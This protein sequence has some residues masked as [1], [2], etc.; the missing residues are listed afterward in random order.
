MRAGDGHLEGFACASKTTCDWQALLRLGFESP[1][2]SGAGPPLAAALNRR[3]TTRTVASTCDRVLGLV[4]SLIVGAEAQMTVVKQV[5]LEKAGGP[6]R[7]GSGLF[8]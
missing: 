3:L 1:L 7:R 5:Q 8:T 6:E 4:R 2:P